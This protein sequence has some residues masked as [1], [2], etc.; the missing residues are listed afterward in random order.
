MDFTAFGILHNRET[1]RSYKMHKS[2][3]IFQLIAVKPR[4]FWHTSPLLPLY[5]NKLYQ[6]NQG[7]F[8]KIVLTAQFSFYI[9]LSVKLTGELSCIGFGVETFR[10]FPVF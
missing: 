1:F 3:A 4:G 2:G 9:I 10:S 6:K 7:F 5:Y 8:S